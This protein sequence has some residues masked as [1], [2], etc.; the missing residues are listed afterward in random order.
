MHKFTIDLAEKPECDCH[1]RN[2]SSEHFILYCFLYTPERQTLF[3]LVEH[4]IPKFSE[5]NKSVKYEILISGLNNTD[6]DYHHLNNRISYAVKNFIIKTK[7]F[8]LN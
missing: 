2:E 5:L 6:P 7:K 3:N 1:F 8:N 4:L